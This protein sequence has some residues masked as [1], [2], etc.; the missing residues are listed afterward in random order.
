MKKFAS[1]A[2]SATLAT[3]LV[4][5]AV[6]GAESSY[7]DIK[8]DFWAKDAI[9]YLTEEGIVSG[10]DNNTFRPNAP[11]KRS[12]AAT[13]LTE[14]LDLDTSDRPDPGFSD[15]DKNDHV[16]EA[17]AVIADE[18]IIEGKDGKFMP[19][20]PLTRAQMAKILTVAFELDGEEN[21]EDFADIPDDYWAHDF[22][23]AIS[24]NDIASGYEE[25][26]TFRPNK[27]TTRAQ[28]ATFLSNAINDEG[29]SVQEDNEVAQL[30]KDTMD[31][32]LNLD[33][34]TFEGDMDMT[35]G[36]DL[37]DELTEEEKAAME[38]AMTMQMNMRGAFQMDPLV[39]ETVIDQT[40]PGFDETITSAAVMADGKSYEYVSDAAF[41]GYP[42]EWDGKYI[43]M[44][45]EELLGE[46]F[47]QFMF[48]IDKQYEMTQE[49]YELFI[50]TF[51]TDAFTLLDEHNAIP[52]GTEYEQIVKFELTEEALV[53][54]ADSFEEDVWPELESIL[55]NPQLFSQFGISAEQAET[56]NEAADADFDEFLSNLSLDDFEIYQA[57][58]SDN[59]IVFDTGNIAIS[60]ADETGSFSFGIEYDMELGNFNEDI[61]LEYGVPENEEDI[62]PFEE[63]LEWQE[64]QLENLEDF[65]E[66]EV[67]EDDVA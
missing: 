29:D 55:E 3:S 62:I 67:D 65:E 48:N 34:Y 37:P 22:I 38:E 57:I 24:A 13:M 35:M 51:G 41:L 42:A 43:E 54:F 32:Q 53:D 49:I 20:K 60:Y 25:D 45:Y 44:D 19:N 39:T 61:Q 11:V 52:E 18:G 59:L 14:A 1:M 17:A 15:V 12:Q 16:Y 21:G 26:G 10:Y 50:D 46:E 31:A 8:D 64:Q 47:S 9:D 58:N 7:K 56:L 28:F 63:V 30:L 36:M 23:Q 6:A 66:V 27:P 40:I 5:P 33:S 4:F 2:L